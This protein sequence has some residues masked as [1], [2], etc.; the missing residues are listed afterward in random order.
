MTCDV[1][2]YFQVQAFEDV[3]ARDA[4]NYLPSR[5]EGNTN[6]VLDLFAQANIKA[7]FFTLGWVAERFPALVRRIIAEGHELA[8]HGMDHVRANH[9][10]RMTFRT[11]VSD[12]K[13]LLEDIGGVPVQGY[14]AASFSIGE[15]NLWALEVLAEIGYRYSSS[16][17]PIKHDLYGMPS[18]PRFAFHPFPGSQFTEIPVTT[19]ELF[20]K[21]LPCGGGGYFRLLPYALSRAAMRRINAEGGACMFYFHPWEIDPDQPRQTQAPLKSRFRHYT[22]LRHMEAKLSRV[23]QDFSWGRVDDVF[24]KVA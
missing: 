15:Q 24:L 1:E 11:D 9:Q 6:R 13:A 12:T 20:G 17:Y 22:N 23:L 7:T 8:S 4:W 18:A 19:V 5:V 21:R 10:D 14:R 16:I 2:D 3:I